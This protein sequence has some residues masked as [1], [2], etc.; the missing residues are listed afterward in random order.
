MYDNAIMKPVI[1][2][3]RDKRSLH[4]VYTYICQGKDKS[5]NDCDY[6]VGLY[7]KREQSRHH[8]LK[9]ICHK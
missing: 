9:Y 8:D 7:H 3:L 1:L 5:G 4:G 6:I 2:Y